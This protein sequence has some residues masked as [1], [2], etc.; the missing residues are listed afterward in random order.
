MSVSPAQY[1]IRV[2]ITR[3]R[4]VYLH[5]LLGLWI[6][7]HRPCGHERRCSCEGPRMGRRQACLPPHP[8]P[9]PFSGPPTLSPSRAFANCC[10][11]T[12]GA[13]RACH[14]CVE[15][16]TR[17][18]N[19]CPRLAARMNLK[20]FFHRFVAV[21]KYTPKSLHP[22]LPLIL[23]IHTIDCLRLS[24]TT[25]MWSAYCVDVNY[26][27]QSVASISTMISPH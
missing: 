17:Y 13:G 1:L 16:S 6:C 26:S 9:Q 25:Y 10:R 24:C 15:P 27:R 11:G 18:A 19:L 7:R 5:R 20:G 8:L 14:C 3:C 2:T 4:L 21:L 22:P 23:L 12:G